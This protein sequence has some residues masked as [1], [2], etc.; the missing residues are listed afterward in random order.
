MNKQIGIILLVIGICLLIWGF[1]LYGAF[2]SHVTR[3]FT[4]S[5]TNKTTTVL[6]IG[7][8]CTVLGIVQLSMKSK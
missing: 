1:N 6:I 8:V 4:G 2:D 5:P 7:A 3:V